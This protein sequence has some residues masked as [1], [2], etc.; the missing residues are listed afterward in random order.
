MMMTRT[1]MASVMRLVW[2][3]N[4]NSCSYILKREKGSLKRA[5]GMPNMC[6]TLKQK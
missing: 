6:F 3:R 5:M 1:P 2:P 4:P